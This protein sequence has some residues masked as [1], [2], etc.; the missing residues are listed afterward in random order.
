MECAD[1]GTADIADRVDQEV[2]AV[3]VVMRDTRAMAVIIMEKDMAKAILNQDLELPTRVNPSCYISCW[4][5]QV[6]EHVNE[7]A[8]V[9]FN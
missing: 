8:F 4:N 6:L 3:P 1:T 2:M 5:E 9:A 7:Q